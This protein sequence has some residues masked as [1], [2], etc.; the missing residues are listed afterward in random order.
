MKKLKF[1]EYSAGE[2]EGTLYDNVVLS[3]G[4]RASKV[5]NLTGLGA[6]FFNDLKEG[7]DVNCEF[8]IN[9]AKSGFV[10]ELTK[11]QKIQK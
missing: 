7:D 6:P 5:K 2:Y 11:I 10:V 1:V 4:M 3:N 8:D 9:I